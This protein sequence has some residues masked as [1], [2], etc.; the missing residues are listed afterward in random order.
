MR[1]ITVKPGTKD[2]AAL[3]DMPEPSRSDGVL[4]VRALALGICGTDREIIA[5]EHGAAPPGEERLILGHESFGVV[6]EAPDG[7]GFARGDHVVGIVRRPDPVPC[8][9]CADGEWDMCRNDRYT[10]RGIKERHGYGSE[11]FRLE[12][13]FAIKIDPRLEHRGVLLEPTS[14]VAKAWDHTDRILTRSRMPSKPRLLVTGAGPIGLL[15][16][17]LG[18]QRGFDVHVFDRNAEGPKVELT[19]ALGGTHHHGEASEVIRDIA[20]DVLMECTGA[21]A[22]I[23][24]ALAQVA[25]N[26]VI[27]LAGVSAPGRKAELDLGYINRTMVLQNQV[28]FGTVNAN[29]THYAAAAK[30]LAEADAQWLDALISRRVPLARWNEAL[31]RR[32]TD[33]KV[34]IDFAA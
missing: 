5:A 19:R 27:C 20:P 14:I 24:A 9:C 15:A 22:V 17:L 11:R 34:V 30:A 23:G 6:E 18:A 1:A 26:G 25:P 28:V 33:I 13:E 3:Q 4:L 12:P 2:S 7:C 10:E 8:V 31:E 16:A 21:A 29:R 32:P